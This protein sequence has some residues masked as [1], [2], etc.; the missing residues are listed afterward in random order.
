VLPSGER[1]AEDIEVVLHGL[2]GVVLPSGERIAEDIEVVLHGLSGVVLPTGERIAEDIEVV[3][4]GLGVVLPSGERIAEDVEV[5]LHGPS[6]VVLPQPGVPRKMHVHRQTGNSSIAGISK[7]LAPDR[8]LLARHHTHAWLTP[9][10]LVAC[11]TYCLRCAFP[12]RNGGSVPRGA[13][14]PALGCM[15][16]VLPAVCVSDS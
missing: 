2:S 1:I 4:H 7:L 14:A 5:V 6:A 13:D 10:L 16:D 3:L 11:A 15:R 9:P 8:A 12:I